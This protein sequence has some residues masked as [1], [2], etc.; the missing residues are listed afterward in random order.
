MPIEIKDLGL[1]PKVTTD[2]DGVFNAELVPSQEI[3]ATGKEVNDPEF[4]K[5]LDATTEWS[6][7]ETERKVS[8]FGMEKM[9]LPW[10]GETLVRGDHVE[11]MKASGYGKRERNGRLI[12]PALPW[13]ADRE[14]GERYADYMA[15]KNAQVLVQYT[16][17]RKL[18]HENGALRLE[19][20]A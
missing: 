10:G 16:D 12:V 17:G 6:D 7:T 5:L 15:R 11:Q 14:I 1:Q 13:Q 9:S 4:G 19:R 20:E 18:V 2:D 8:I 3:V